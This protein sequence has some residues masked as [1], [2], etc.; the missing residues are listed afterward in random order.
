MTDSRT[1]RVLSRLKAKA[2]P[3]IG[4]REGGAFGG[5][6]AGGACEQDDLVTR[7]A[8]TSPARYPGTAET[9]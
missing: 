6:F 8:L 2:T 1:P 7:E 4:R 9:G 5:V 3:S